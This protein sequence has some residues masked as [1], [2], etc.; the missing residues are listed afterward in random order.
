MVYLVAMTKIDKLRISKFAA[1]PILVCKGE[2]EFADVYTFI[3]ASNLATCFCKHW[4]ALPTIADGARS[5]SVSGKPALINSSA[6]AWLE[7]WSTTAI[8]S[9]SAALASSICKTPWHGQR[10]SSILLFPWHCEENHLDHSAVKQ[11]FLSLMA[12]SWRMG[13]LPWSSPKLDQ[14]QQQHRIHWAHPIPWT[15]PNTVAWFSWIP[16]TNTLKP[17]C[18]SSECMPCR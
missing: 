15:L 7:A 9:R 10:M 6:V 18:R 2:R 1:C 12:S 5:P 8:G 3:K 14:G 17:A 16:K 4:V 11:F 13:S